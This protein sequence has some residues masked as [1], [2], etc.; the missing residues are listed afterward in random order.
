MIQKWNTGTHTRIMRELCEFFIMAKANRFLLV[1]QIKITSFSKNY[2]DLHVTLGFQLSVLVRVLAHT[3]N[4]PANYFL[5][6]YDTVM[7]INKLLTESGFNALFYQSSN[8]FQNF[9]S[10]NLFRCLF[11]RTDIIDVFG[12]IKD[13]KHS[14]IRGT[15]RKN[16]RQSEAAFTVYKR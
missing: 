13:L 11:N 2:L 8:S 10:E 16:L 1:N 15:H 6:T 7:R 14:W 12:Y 4:I 9:K 3:W 5:I